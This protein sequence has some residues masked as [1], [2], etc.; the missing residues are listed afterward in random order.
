MAVQALSDVLEYRDSPNFLRGDALSYAPQHGRTY[1]RAQED[2][3]LEGVYVLRAAA[4]PRS[5]EIPVVY[6]CHA[7]DEESAREIHRK[8]WNQNIVPFLLVHTD[9]KVRL[10]A[11]FNYSKQ[12]TARAESGLLREGSLRQVAEALAAFNAHSIDDGTLWREWGTKVTPEKRVDWR[13]LDNLS[14]LGSWLRANGLK[15][16]S[17]AHGLI[18]KY[19]Y[20]H[21][22]L[23]RGILSEK[24]LAEWGITR[25]HVFSRDATLKAFRELVDR[26]D[27]WLNGAI[28]PITRSELASIR[29]EH[30]KRVAGAFSGDMMDGQLHLDFDAY[31]FSHIPI[32]T[33]SVIYEQFLH[34]PE[35]DGGQSEGRERGAYYTPVPLVSYILSELNRRRPLRAGMRVLDASC[36]SGAFLVQCYRNLIEQRVHECGGT[37]PA[38]T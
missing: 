22:L 30:L 17:R 16:R 5:P 10:Y 38:P 1:R 37:R 21:Y 20:L 9:T 3:G 27:E 26:L 7:K 14:Q 19:V 29:A 31:D 13:L 4:E 12:E 2:C 34:A 15:D 35:D 36:G 28:F 11:G 33:I 32:E 6:L 25:E 18:G 8:V 24:K 23:A